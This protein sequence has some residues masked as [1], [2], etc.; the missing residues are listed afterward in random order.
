[1]DANSAGSSRPAL[2][3]GGGGALGVI[4][5]AYVTAALEMGFRPE[6]IVGTSVG[7]LNGTSGADGSIWWPAPAK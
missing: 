6:M 3:L 1:M 7:S 5:A 4:Q 2:V